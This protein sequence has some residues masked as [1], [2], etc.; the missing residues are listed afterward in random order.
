MDSPKRKLGRRQFLAESTAAAAAFTAALHAMQARAAEETA[1]AKPAEKN[2]EPVN[3]AIVGVGTEGYMLLDQALK[4]PG[5][6]CKA[7]CDLRP[8]QKEKAVKL[9]KGANGYDSFDEML[10]KEKGI[11]ALIIATPLFLHAQMTI[12]AIQ[13]GLNVY[14]EKMMAMTVADCKAM[15][16]AAKDAKKVL[17]FGHHRH[18]DPGY[19]TAEKLI[20]KEKALGTITHI[21]AQWNRNGKANPLAKWV[22]PVTD[23][24]KKTN[25]ALLK[26]WGY[27]DLAHLI[28]WRLYKAYSRGL[29]AEL[30]SHQVDVANWFLKSKPTGVM[31]IGGID[32]WKD[33]RE[34]FDN[35]QCIYEYPGGQKLQY[36]SIT[37]NE[38]DGFTEE[39]M[40]TERT[41]ITST[42]GGQLY[43]EPGAT[44]LPWE[45]QAKKGTKGEVK[46][47][48]NATAAAAEG[49]TKHEGAAIPGAKA[50]AA[51]PFAP[52]GYA[53][54]SFF[55]HIRKDDLNP[56]CSAQ[57][58]LDCA[59]A[60]IHADTAME[61]K[62]RV[63]IPASDYEF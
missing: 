16:K 45:K 58:A 14:C 43:A 11:K 23:D 27:K 31:G 9:S 22:R 63:E 37:T 4:Q 48:P 55:D 42:F 19:L 39:F 46:L 28:N 24:D 3:F 8:V 40:G 56:A 49:K 6:V 29:T 38:Y 41:L 33:G 34:I 52:Y 54:N 51:D 50:G 53:L 62:G 7:V 60:C 1:A 5:S 47:D 30:M 15:A 26:K 25:E 59:V 10:E 35:I 57:V 12:A 36:Q 13:A 61:K 44:P 20:N 32:T 2:V 17:Q 21:R 18:Y